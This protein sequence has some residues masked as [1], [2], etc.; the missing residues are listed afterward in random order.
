[1]IKLVTCELGD[2][3]KMSIISVIIFF[4]IHLAAPILKRRHENCLHTQCV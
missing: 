2:L 1:M 3:D 4:I